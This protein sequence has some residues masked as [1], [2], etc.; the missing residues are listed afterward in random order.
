MQQSQSVQQSQCACIRES[1]CNLLSGAFVDKEVQLFTGAPSVG[2]WPICYELNITK[3]LEYSEVRHDFTRVNWDYLSSVLE[4]DVTENF[5]VLIKQ[6]P[7]QFLQS[8]N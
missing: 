6:L 4:V 7:S 5:D 3:P 2:H 1:V 8:I